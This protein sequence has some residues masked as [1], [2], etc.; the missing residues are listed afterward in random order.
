MYTH[1]PQQKAVAA[2]SSVVKRTSF[3]RSCVGGSALVVLTLA[4]SHFLTGLFLRG[5]SSDL[6]G[7][8]GDFYHPTFR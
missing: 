8:A 4:L 2:S 6:V 3:P 1:H 7:D 5:P